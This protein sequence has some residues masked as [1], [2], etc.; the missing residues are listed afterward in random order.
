MKQTSYLAKKIMGKKRKL[1]VVLFL[2]H[3]NMRLKDLNTNWIVPSI[4]SILGDFH[5]A[6]PFIREG[7][8]TDSLCI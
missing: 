8:E 1:R 6:L 4:W 2:R 5:S 3:V 7:Q